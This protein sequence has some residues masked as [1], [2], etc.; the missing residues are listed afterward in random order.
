MSTQI[1]MLETVAAGFGELVD[2][3]VFVGGIVTGFLR[4]CD[5]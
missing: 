5:L 2:K 4:Y 3:V 1:R